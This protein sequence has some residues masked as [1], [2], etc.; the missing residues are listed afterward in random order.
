MASMQFARIEVRDSDGGVVDPK[1]YGID[2][3][4]VEQ[5]KVPTQYVIALFSELWLTGKFSADSIER[6]VGSTFVYGITHGGD[7]YL[8]GRCAD[9]DVDYSTRGGKAY[10]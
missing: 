1:G 7:E 2:V 8:V 3:E 6:L 9:F 5:E 10:E 4:Y